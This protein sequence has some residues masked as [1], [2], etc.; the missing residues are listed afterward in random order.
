MNYYVP[1]GM[2]MYPNR[3]PYEVRENTQESR[4]FLMLMRALKEE[5]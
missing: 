2:D 4:T 1:T 5:I 3:S